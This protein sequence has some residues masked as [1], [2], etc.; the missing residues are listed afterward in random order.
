MSMNPK[1]AVSFHLLE[2]SGFALL[3]EGEPLLFLRVEVKVISP[4]RQRID[5]VAKVFVIVSLRYHVS[6]ETLI[7]SPFDEEQAH[8]QRL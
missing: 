4:L 2:C 1:T 3:R 5:E 7:S 6:F 8:D